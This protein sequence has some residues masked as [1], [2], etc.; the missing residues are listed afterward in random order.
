MARTSGS[1]ITPSKTSRALVLWPSSTPSLRVL[2]VV[3]VVVVVAVGLGWAGARAS[4][5]CNTKLRPTLQPAVDAGQ[6]LQ[7]T[8][9]LA[10]RSRRSWFLAPTD[11]CP[12]FPSLTTTP[13]INEIRN[14]KSE[15]QISRCY[16]S[17]GLR[18]LP[19]K[20]TRT[21]PQAS[22]VSSCTCIMHASW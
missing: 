17:K 15:N 14:L 20:A 21:R 8:R 7:S 18:V 1:S 19:R 4:T 11:P 5:S 6:P 3:V 12:I 22:G 10:P 2:V 16:A 13:M 9:A